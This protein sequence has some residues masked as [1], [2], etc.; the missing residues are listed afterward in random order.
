M[1][2]CR[3]VDQHSVGSLHASLQFDDANEVTY[4]LGP[5]C[6]TPC[7]TKSIILHSL[8]FSQQRESASHETRCGRSIKHLHLPHLE[9]GCP[10]AQDIEIYNTWRGARE[11]CVGT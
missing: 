9:M 11:C 3:R 1:A 10:G 6:A 7:H 5:R 4:S 2:H 8:G